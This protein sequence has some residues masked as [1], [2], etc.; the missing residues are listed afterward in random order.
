MNSYDMK[1][2]DDE[3]D[4]VLRIYRIA[5]QCGCKFYCGRDAHQPEA[6]D[7]SNAVFERAIDLQDLQE[8]DKFVTG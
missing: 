1:F 4:A 5:K 8:E 6:L 3:A 7:K 2:A